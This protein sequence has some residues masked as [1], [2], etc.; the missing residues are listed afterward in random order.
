MSMR[1]DPFRDLDRLAELQGRSFPRSML[2]MDAF[3]RD[4]EFVVQFDL[5]GADPRSIDLSVEKNVLTVKAERPA[6]PSERDEVIVTE[7]R[8]GSFT[9]QLFLGESLDT[10]HIKASYDNG[11][12]TLAIPVAEKAKPHRIRVDLVP[13]GTQ[14]VE[15]G[16]DEAQPVEARE[17]VAAAA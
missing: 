7:R 16:P 11:V 15:G 1:F 8:C 12:L 9:R 3:R 2:A 4:Q 6:T 10:D 14:P 17:A 13:S 5:P